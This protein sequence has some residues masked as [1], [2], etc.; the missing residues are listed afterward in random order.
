MVLFFCEPGTIL[1][2]LS[3]C[4]FRES[5]RESGTALLLSVCFRPSVHVFMQKAAI[6]K[7]ICSGMTA[8]FF[9]STILFPGLL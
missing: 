7:L 5:G 1:L 9:L 6:P 3:P 8:Y 4:L 2:L